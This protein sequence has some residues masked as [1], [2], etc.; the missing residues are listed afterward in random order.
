MEITKREIIASISIIAIMLMIGILLS[1][2]ISE[3]QMDSNEKYNKA[4]KIEGK[5]LF[6]YGMDTNVGNAFVYGE[7]E[8]I[9]S[10]GYPEIDGKYLYV[11]KVK[12]RY[13]MHTRTVTTTVNGKTR[14][15]TETYWTWDVVGR[16]E[17]RTK[18]VKFCDI[19][20]NSSQF[21][22]PSG[23][24]INTIKESSHVR[25]KY[26]GYPVKSK[27]TIFTYLSN[28]NIDKDGVLFYRDKTI[29]EAMEDLEANVGLIIFWIVWSIVIV[30]AVCG[31][32]Y[33][34]N[35]WLEN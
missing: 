16:E 18:K 22:I 5:E 4:V 3:W 7:L 9:D 1:S 10:V 21:I 2:K 29:D 14:T 13:T 19:E 25:Y 6:Q 8:C 12:E 20:F 15:R 31:F 11:E 24:Y 27:G 28:G 17:L 26:Y 34:D 23:E 33:L 35:R 30:A 32:Y